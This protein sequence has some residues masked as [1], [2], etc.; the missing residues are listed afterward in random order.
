MIGLLFASIVIDIGECVE[1]VG[2]NVDVIASDAMTLYCDSLTFICTGD[3]MKL[4][5]ANVALSLDRKSVV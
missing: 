2:Y 4:A 5:A 1:L 3:C